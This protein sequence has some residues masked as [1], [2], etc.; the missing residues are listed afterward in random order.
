MDSYRELC[1]I[2]FK[3]AHCRNVIWLALENIFIY[4]KEARRRSQVA[5]QESAKLPFVGP[6]PTVASNCF[7][8]LIY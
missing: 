4:N 5:R 8:R 3:L 7:Y 1:F 6:N 2:D